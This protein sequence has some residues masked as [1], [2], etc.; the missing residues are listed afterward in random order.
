MCLVQ[1]CNLAGLVGEHLKV[2]VAVGANARLKG[3]W[4][5]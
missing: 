5:A 4:P 1:R 3:S 2:T